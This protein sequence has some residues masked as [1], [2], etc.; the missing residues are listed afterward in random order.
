VQV[1]LR[2]QAHSHNGCFPSPDSTRR[3]QKVRCKLQTEI[4]KKPSM[5]ISLL[6]SGSCSIMNSSLGSEGFQ[7]VTD[8]KAFRATYKGTNKPKTRIHRYLK[9][10]SASQGSVVRFALCEI[11]ASS[12]CLFMRPIVN[13]DHVSQCRSLHKPSNAIPETSPCSSPP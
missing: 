13:H 1:E 5:F 12:Q 11:I 3:V 7:E 9:I 10:T 6:C 4:W 8:L 2:V